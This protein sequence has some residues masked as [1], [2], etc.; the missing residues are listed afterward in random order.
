[1][2]TMSF[3]RSAVKVQG[4]RGQMPRSR[5]KIR[6]A[7][8]HKTTKGSN[9]ECITTWGRPSH[10]SP[11]SLSLRRHAK[12]EVAEYTHCRIIAFLLLIHHFMLWPWHSTSWPWPLTFDLEHVQRIACDV[13]KLHVCTKFE[14]NRANRG[15]V[16]ILN[17]WP[18]C[19][20]VTC[21]TR[22]W[23]NFHKVWPLTTY[24]CLNYGVFLCWYVMS[25]CDLDLWPLDLERYVKRH[26]IKVC[27][28]LEQNRAIPGWIID[29]F[30]NFCTRYVTLKPLALP[31]PLPYVLRWA[32]G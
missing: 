18:N 17:I 2:I 8:I 14:R 1:M 22:L 29:N 31:L 10:A 13:M 3:P 26:V 28:K 4:S 25:S 15:G 5:R 30:A 27:T 16:A 19:H 12:F 9:C 21:C 24:P 6:Y 11:F 23:D 32:L 20:C 7:K